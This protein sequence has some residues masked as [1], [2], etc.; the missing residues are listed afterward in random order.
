MS[1]NTSDNTKTMITKS[2]RQLRS[3]GD[4]LVITE[5]N[6]QQ[7]T[8]YCSKLTD[9]MIKE[10]AHD[11]DEARKMLECCRHD[12]QQCRKHNCPECKVCPQNGGGD[13]CAPY[14]NK[15]YLTISVLL[16]S[17]LIY[18]TYMISVFG[19]G[20]KILPLDADYWIS[21]SPNEGFG[22][23]IWNFIKSLL[24]LVISV[25]LA[26]IFSAVNIFAGPIFPSYFGFNTR[27]WA[28][29]YYFF[30]TFLMVVYIC[31]IFYPIFSMAS[32]LIALAIGIFFNWEFNDLM[33]S[34]KEKRNTAMRGGRSVVV[35]P[36]TIPSSIKKPNNIMGQY[37]SGQSGLIEMS[38]LHV[39]NQSADIE[40]NFGPF[41][42][43]LNPIESIKRHDKKISKKGKN[44][45]SKD[46]ITQKNMK[47]IA[48]MTE[49]LDAVHKKA[50][51]VLGI[52]SQTCPPCP[53]K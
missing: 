14:K 26:P 15:A 2:G 8:V 27:F 1:T 23:R 47:Q 40:D 50:T 38:G 34:E 13:D 39:G 4:S 5:P 42:L 52:N 20:Y 7:Q 19:V 25:F 9:K 10:I 6:G 16:V 41:N 30:M 44:V 35:P 29:V 43:L 12:I 37:T 28:F 53:R 17:F 21:I 3:D 36:S 18:G 49:S 46:L 31:I 48:A 45:T 33:L 51:K 24:R 22:D 11:P 32:F